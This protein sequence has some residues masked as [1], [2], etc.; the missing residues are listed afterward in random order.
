VRAPEIP[1][2]LWTV[3]TRCWAQEPAERPTFLALL[4]EFRGGNGYVL[5]GADRSA[6]V[7][8]EGRVWGDFG[9]PKNC[10]L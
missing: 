9:P 7:D 5:D 6:V 4:N 1:D 3:I 10:T 2:A 8:Y